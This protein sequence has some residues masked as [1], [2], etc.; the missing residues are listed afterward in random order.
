M[1][2]WFQE[3]GGQL[4]MKAVAALQDVQEGKT[5]VTAKLVEHPM[6]QDFLGSQDIVE[7]IQAQAKEITQQYNDFKLKINEYTMPN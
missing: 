5:G 3:T 1:N 7:K 6:K 4:S 2:N